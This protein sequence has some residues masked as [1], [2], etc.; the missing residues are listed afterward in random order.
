MKMI[1]IDEF[2][3][4]ELRIGEI[5]AVESLQ[6]SDRL[7]KI[8]VDLGSERRTVVGSLAQSYSTSELQGLQVVLA[9][10]VAPRV[11]RGVQSQGMLLGVACS[12]PKAA[13]LL[14]VQR[15]AQNGAAV[16]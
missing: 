7:L 2:R 8:V 3:K 15:R 4:L 1:S 16:S 13:T 5:T 6:S 11:I 12:D 10:N 9:A 14:T